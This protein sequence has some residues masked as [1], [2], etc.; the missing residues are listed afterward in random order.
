[1]RAITTSL[2][3]AAVCACAPSKPGVDSQGGDA[4]TAE[5]TS[6]IGHSSAPTGGGDDGP[7]PVTLT[8]ATVATVATVTT[9]PQEPVTTSGAEPTTTRA[10][11]ITIDEDGVP[12]FPE[13]TEMAFIIVPS[14]VPPGECQVWKDLCPEGQKC[15]AS[16]GPRAPTWHE[17]KCLPVVDDPGQPGD[18]CVVFGHPTS[19]VD[20]CE[21]H[22]MCWAVD[23]AL[24]GVCV[25]LCTGDAID[26]FCQIDG[27][28]CVMANDDVL[29]LC[30]P[31]CNPL[32]VNCPAG[33]VCIPTVDNFA[34]APD[35]SGDDGQLF[36]PCAAGNACDPGLV[37][38]SAA[39]A[40]ACA[41]GSDECCL[42][43]CD[44]FQAGGCPPGQMCAE[45]VPGNLPALGEVG[46]CVD[47]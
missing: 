28:T 5:V 39:H 38:A 44:V 16:A 36:T 26:H 20:T 18:P 3:V 37:C 24:H 47:A 41:G 45:W 40:A 15:A 10:D 11:V 1:M 4:S 25:A 33:Q 19:G 21:K 35:V 30:L 6:T 9:A 13:E 23:Q 27:T 22:A 14:D 7:G 32:V 2:I 34:C 31:E 43:M 42:A 46:V 17:L 8:G 12:I 29:A